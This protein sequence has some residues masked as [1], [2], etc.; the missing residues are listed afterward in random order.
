M[1]ADREGNDITLEDVFWF[2]F[3]IT[4][5]FLIFGGG[6]STIVTNGVCK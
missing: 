3:W 4:F 6:E 5:L 1:K 2:V